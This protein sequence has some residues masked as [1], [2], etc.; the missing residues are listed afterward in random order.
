M[1]KF[2]DYFSSDF[3]DLEPK[4]LDINALLCDEMYLVSGDFYG[5]QKF[6]FDNLSTKNAAKVLRAKSA[7]CELFTNVVAKFICHKFQIDTKHILSC[8]AG[9]FEILTPKFSL[10]IFNEIK[11]EIDEYFIKNFFGISGIGLVYVACKRDD[12]LASNRYKDLREKVSNAI[13][14]QKFKKFSLATQP[15]V[16]SY[17]KSITNQ[18]LCKICNTRKISKNEKCE[19]CDIFVKLGEILVSDKNE[20][21]SNE[22][23]LDFFK[24]S[25]KLNESIKSYVAKQGYEI[26]SFSELATRANGE[27]ALAVLK[28]DVDNMGNFIKNTDVTDSFANFDTFSKSI[29]NFFS[30]YIPRKMREQYPDS[31]TIFAGGDDLLLVGS[32]DKMIELAIFV[33]QE[34]LKFVKNKHLTISFGI[35]LA[36]PSIP[37]SYIANVAEHLLESSKELE[38][39]DGISMFNESVKWDDYINVR[40]QVLSCFDEFKQHINTAFLYRILEFCDMS[41]NVK[42][43]I[44]NT[45]WRSKL[46]YS[47]YRNF[48]QVKDEKKEKILLM[49]DNQIKKNPK[50][51][52]MVVCEYIY[53]RREK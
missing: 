25:I 22:L 50:E 3:K 4:L 53:K 29:N 49:L 48:E 11:S 31:Y 24:T 45:M 35:V 6:I 15:P 21:T 1:S 8:T 42:N 39:K 28:A 18:T 33:R 36:K 46:N 38:N 7:F 43:D 23:G 9:K 32:Y 26:A 14:T 34:F 19:I 47:F 44:N 10:E 17:D 40:E 37:I 41:K 27:N 13:E 20:I 51:M 52:K 16:L 12:F 30:L 2:N 5:I